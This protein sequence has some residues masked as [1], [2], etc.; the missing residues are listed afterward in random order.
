[1]NKTPF[2]ESHNSDDELLAEYHFDYKKAKPNRF[3]AQ[4][5]RKQLLKVVVLDEDVAQVFK[6]PESV[7]KVLRALIESMPQVTDGDTA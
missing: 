6:T 7:N 1:M 3:A 2:E 5:R 4:S